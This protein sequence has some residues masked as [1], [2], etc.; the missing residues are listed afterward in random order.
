[1]SQRWGQGSTVA[2]LVTILFALAAVQ[3]RVGGVGGG[4][5]RGEEREGNTDRSLG[6]Q[7]CGGISLHPEYSKTGFPRDKGC[8]LDTV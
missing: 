4:G 1:M 8:E 6:F 5:G 2:L 7:V 3:A